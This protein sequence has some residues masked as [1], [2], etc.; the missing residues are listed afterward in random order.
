[1]LSDFCNLL[2]NCNQRKQCQTSEYEAVEAESTW[3]FFFLTNDVIENACLFIFN[4][5]LFG[6]VGS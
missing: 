2:N 6:S 1:M 5:Y 3:V 4:I